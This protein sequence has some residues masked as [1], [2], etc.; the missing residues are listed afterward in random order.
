MKGHTLLLV[1][2]VAITP[3]L[4]VCDVKVSNQDNGL[5]IEQLRDTGEVCSVSVE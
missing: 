3:S 5:R 4:V 1:L 2:L